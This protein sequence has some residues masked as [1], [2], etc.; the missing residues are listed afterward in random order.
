MS[1]A[2]LRDACAIVGVGTNH[3]PTAAGK[4]EL[5]TLVDALDAALLDAGLTRADIDGLMINVAPA[6]ASM[7]ALPMIVGLPNV[8]CAFQSWSHGRMNA[9]VVGVAALQVFSGLSR[10]TACISTFSADSFRARRHSEKTGSD[11]E[12]T[13]E[14]GGP[15]LEAPHYGNTA[16]TGGAALAMQK[17]LMKYGYQQEDLGAVAVEQRAW[18]QANPNARL[19]GKPLTREEYNA[20]RFVVEPLRIHDN[21]V[22]ANTAVCVIVA[23][24]EHAKDLRQQPVLISGFQA[25][26]SSRDVFVF[27]RTNLGVGQ[28]V[29][30]PY[31]APE[32][33]A[34]YRMAGIGRDE[35]DILGIFDTVSP[36]VPFG[37]EE[38]GFCAEGEALA[39]LNEGH[40][41]PSGKLPINT[42]GGSLSEG[43]TGGWGAIVE[44]VHQLRG[45]AGSRQVPN[46]D[47][48]Q[49][50]MVDRSSLMLRRFS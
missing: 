29:D 4:P 20:S 50:L 9:M 24:T 19:N 10:Y 12:L 41:G 11:I 34:V 32:D 26:T 25:S 46:V 39:W 3:Y 8:G 28:Q 31:T 43:L 35:V 18:A 2:D 30:R 44:L 47:V 23:S 21:S 17:Y 48:G 27:G 1:I 14:G 33:M 40:A 16:P 45:T 36:V 49:Y 6:E 22:L 15:H 13:R 42:H 38:F 5:E 37:L 7:D